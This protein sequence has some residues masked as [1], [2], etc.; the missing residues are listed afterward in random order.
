MKPRGKLERAHAEARLDGRVALLLAMVLLAVGLIG[1]TGASIAFAAAGP[2][3]VDAGTGSA[4]TPPMVLPGSAAGISRSGSVTDPCITCGSWIIGAV[5]GPIGQRVAVRHGADPVASRLGIFRIRRADAA[6][7]ARDL[8]RS[9][10]L[11]FAEPDVAVRPAGYPPDLR[12][13]QQT[14]L[15][16]IVN[17]VD[18]TPPQVG[19]TSP[20]LGL[21]EQGIDPSHPDLVKANLTGAKPSGTL[22]LDSHGTAVAGIA[23]SP[24]ADGGIRGVLPGARMQYFPAGAS[25]ATAAASVVDASRAGARVINMSYTMPKCYTHYLATQYAVS[26]DVL[27]VAAAGNTGDQGNAVQWPAADP[28]V[29][30]VSAVDGDNLIAPFSTRNRKVDITAPGDRVIAPVTTSGGSS[31]DGTEITEHVWALVSGTSFS[32]PM[33]AAA[34]TWIRQVRPGYSAAQTRQLLLRSATDLGLS[35]RDPLYG[36]GL[37]D[38]DRALIGPRPPDDPFEPNDDI[39]LLK[40]TGLIPGTGPLWKP[41]GR[42]VVRLR[43]TLSAAKDPVD[44]YRIRIPARKRIL[45]MASQIEGDVRITALKPNTRTLKKTRGK[46]IIK[47]DRPH[48]RTEGIKVGNLRRKSQEIWLAVTP[49]RKAR[50]DHATY[51]LTIHPTR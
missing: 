18:T 6:G 22:T 30:S 38:I 1:S 49:G 3:A 32:A 21:I 24:G 47:S 31:S 39:A 37:L 43:A 42:R 27:P 41:G 15:D 10:R 14:W 28:H 17:P 23:G 51:R 46:V 29:L 40:G 50:E 11:R 45:V 33:V 16:Q 25:C 48:P 44:V 34:A 26:R 4:S 13:G 5:P 20:M 12:A 19:T 9:G 2:S 8:D 35:G 36:N 7:L